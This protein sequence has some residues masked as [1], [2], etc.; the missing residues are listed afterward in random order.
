MIKHSSNR[1]ISMASEPPLATGNQL[2]LGKN[3]LDWKKIVCA[4]YCATS[5]FCIAFVQEF[6]LQKGEW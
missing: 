6:A 5:V 4:L 3:W 1:P 2:W